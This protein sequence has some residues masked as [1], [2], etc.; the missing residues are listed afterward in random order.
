MSGDASDSV[1]DCGS[2]SDV[3]FTETPSAEVSMSR[4]GGGHK[5]SSMCAVLM[6]TS[7][8]STTPI[9]NIELDL[10]DNRSY[11]EI[12]DD[13]PWQVQVLKAE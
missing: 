3:H 12:S 8:K 6:V 7:S 13:A 1:P 10:G 11:A 5:R 4:D 2:E 9:A